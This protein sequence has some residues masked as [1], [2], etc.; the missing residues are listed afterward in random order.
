VDDRK[1]IEGDEIE[2]VFTG[3]G[4]R[5]LHLNALPIRDEIG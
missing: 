5:T 2:P 3:L 1:R 4:K